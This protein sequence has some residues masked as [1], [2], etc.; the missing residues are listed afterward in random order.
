MREPRYFFQ[1]LNLIC[2]ALYMTL[3][4]DRKKSFL[5]QEEWKRR[6]KDRELWSGRYR[7]PGTRASSQHP[8]P[9]TCE[10]HF[11]PKG[12]SGRLEYT[13]DVSLQR[14]PRQTSWTIPKGLPS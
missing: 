1:D 2:Q 7:S 11:D 4:T 8:S 5:K 3:E 10:I 9:I 13:S 12:I 14:T 6:W